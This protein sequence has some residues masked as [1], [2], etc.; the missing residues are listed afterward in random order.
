MSRKTQKMKLT[1]KRQRDGL[2]KIDVKRSALFPQWLTPSSTMSL[3]V[4]PGSNET[5]RPNDAH[6][7]SIKLKA[8]FWFLTLDYIISFCRL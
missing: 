5:I 4:L 6:E 2:T 8:Q 3:E 1:V 7:V